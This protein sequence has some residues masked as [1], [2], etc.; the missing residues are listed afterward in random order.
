MNNDSKVVNDWILATQDTI[1]QLQEWLRYLEM[2]HTNGWAE[3]DDF[4]EVC[5]QLRE[6][7]LG[8]WAGRAGGH[9]LEALAQAVG[10]SGGGAP[11]GEQTMHNDD[12]PL[13]HLF[14][15]DLL[16]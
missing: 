16:D 14:D 1:Y 9:G 11:D 5:G 7:G 3:P 8:E 4:Q 2:W 13:Y 10:A 6:A 12:L 15:D